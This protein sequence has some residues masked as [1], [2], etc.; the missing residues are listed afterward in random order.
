MGRIKFKRHLFDANRNVGKFGNPP[1]L[2]TGDR[3]FKSD[4]SDKWER[5]IEKTERQSKPIY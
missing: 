5:N 4:H 2:G 1:V 3:Q